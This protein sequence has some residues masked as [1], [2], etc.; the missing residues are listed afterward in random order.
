MLPGAF[1]MGRQVPQTL[2]GVEIT[3]RVTGCMALA[4]LDGYAPSGAG[5]APTMSGILA[6]K[7]GFHEPCEPL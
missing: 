5:E 7:G 2:A 6:K 4:G 1:S 3:C